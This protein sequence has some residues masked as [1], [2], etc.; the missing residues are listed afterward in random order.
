[1]SKKKPFLSRHL[2]PKINLFPQKK[3]SKIGLP[4]GSMVFTGKKKIEDVTIEL[5]QYDEEFYEQKKI[6]LKE[7][8]SLLENRKKV[9]WIDVDGLHDI[10]TLEEIRQIFSINKLTM[11]DILDVDQRPK[12]EVVEDYLYVSVK[13]IRKEP[14]GDALDVEQVSFLLRGDLVI[15][16]QEREGDVFNYVRGRLENSIGNIRKRGADYLLYALLDSIIDSYFIVL[17]GIGSRLEDLE[18]AAINNAGDETL[19]RIYFQRKQLMA[20]RKAIYPLREVSVV[21]QKHEG[22]HVSQEIHPFLQDLHENITQVIELL[23]GFRDFSSSLL[24]LCMN[25]LSNKMNEIMKVLTVISTIFIPLSFVAGVYGMNFNNM[26]ELH[27]KNGYFYVL[28]GMFVA[29]MGMLFYFRW[30]KWF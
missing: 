5:T 7:L 9:T 26:P 23:D 21:F 30:K 28:G 15:T 8:P 22:P 4:P 29:V 6:S 14:E 12:M 3:G 16:F 18:E 25:I 10:E 17:E 11:E 24:D 1:M 27:L 13:M 20:I 19:N 2:I